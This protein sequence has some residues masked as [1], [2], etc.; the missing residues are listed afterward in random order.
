MTP[1]AGRFLLVDTSDRIAMVGIYEGE[2]VLAETRACQGRPT[3]GWVNRAI[4]ESQKASGT[5]L[6]D[7]KFLACGIGPGGFTSLRIGMSLMKAMSQALGIPMVGVNR[8]EAAAMG[9]AILSPSSSAHFLVRLPAAQNLEYAALYRI[10]SA[11]LPVCVRKPAAISPQKIAGIRLPKSAIRVT[12]N[13]D[14]FYLGIPRVAHLKA[15]AGLVESAEKLLPLY[16][17]GATFGPPGSA[18]KVARKRI[19]R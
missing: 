17:R 3:L 16:L 12:A 6:R 10:D 15:C 5:K 18:V 14:F 7:L 13:L 1:P 11:A 9:R 8:L 19:L 2:H 4:L